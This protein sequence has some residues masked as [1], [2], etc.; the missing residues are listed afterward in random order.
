MIALLD[1][2]WFLRTKILGNVWRHRIANRYKYQ[3]K[4]IFYPHRRSITG[5]C[6]CTERIHNCLYNHHTDRH[7]GLLEN[8]R[9]GNPKHGIQLLP[10]KPAKRTLI[11]PHPMN[12]NHEGQHCR[13]PLCN[14]SRK[15][16]TEHAQP[17][18]GHHPE[19]HK[20]IQYRRYD[21]KH[22]RNLR[23]PDGSK[24]G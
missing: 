17:Q 24:H 12:K 14:K 7:G 5:K 21:Q 1:T 13:N 2:L 23:L 3:R 18:T 22:Q 10:F 20:N 9:N 8:R 15:G 19:I 4:N 11:L 6:L 16:C